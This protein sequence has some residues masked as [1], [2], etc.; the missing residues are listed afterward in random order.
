MSLS[1]QLLGPPR[2]ALA[3]EDQGR[4]R[5]AK[6][7]ALLALLARS[8]GPI[9]RSR[10]AELLFSEA[11]DPLGALRWTASQL[12]RLLGAAETVAGDPMALHLPAD[13]TL[14]VDVVLR[15]RWAEALELPGLGRPLLEGIDPDAG[16]SYELWLAAERRHLDGSSTALLQEAASAL[17][18]RDEP[19]A[20]VAVAN[21]L[22]ALDPYDENGQVLL[23]QSLVAAG[24]HTA[25]EE[26][27]QSCTELFCAELGIEPSPALAAAAQ[28]RATPVRA[29]AVTLRAQL[30]AGQ[31]AM[32]AGAVD[33][34]LTTLRGVADGASALGD[35]PLAIQAFL[36]LGVALVH[37]TRGTDQEAVTILHRTRALADAVG[38]DASAAGACRELGYVEFLRGR[39]D[40]AETWL[41]EARTLAV[42]DDA[43][44]GWI[45]S[46]SGSCLS[47]TAHYTEAEQALRRAVELTARA[48]DGR[49][50][51]FATTHLCRLHYLRGELEEA[52]ETG[53][54]AIELA[55]SEGWTS[56]GP[57]PETWIALVELG[58]Q[59]LEEAHDLLEHA[60][61]MACQIGDACWQTL[62]LRGLGLVSADQSRP[63]EALDRLQEAPTHCRKMPDAYRWAEAYAL[64][65]LV[66]V[67]VTAG[68]EQAP[69]WLEQLDSLADRHGFREL[70]A[71]AHLHH[72]RLGDTAA[73]SLAE[74]LVADIDNPRLA[75]DI[76]AGAVSTR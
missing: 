6:T 3:G 14:D 24:D 66:D 35:D 23:V 70:Q 67:A 11:D 29:S 9:P 60:W 43:E 7:W 8:G 1:I 4:P 20:A 54:R 19:E 44:L 25:A 21:R 33:A 53:L 63:D 56:F 45:D 48:G 76:A 65:A 73:Q 71:R 72:A 75:R 22:V 59:N 26:R 49:G 28:R 58:L 16:A 50:E 5:G 61:A 13:T 47:D 40:R 12:R 10:I 57:Y 52:A 27:V 18:A 30:E 31:A 39:Y 64:E 62:S 34:G 55:R 32:A 41:A 68:D 2:V 15:G 69:T 37:T 74:L 51:A 42:G 17:L 38:D 36:S 46:V